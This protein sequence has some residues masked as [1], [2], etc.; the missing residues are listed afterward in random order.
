[1]YRRPP[2]STRTDTLFPY[3]TLFRSLDIGSHALAVTRT[4]RAAAATR[5][6]TA[7]RAQI[8]AACP[9]DATTGLAKGADALRAYVAAL[10]KDVATIAAPTD[11]LTALEAAVDD[12]KATQAAAPGRQDESRHAPAAAENTT[13]G[14]A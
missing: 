7:V 1:M 10:D 2:R 5:E 3:P 13:T 4:E 14:H 12:A 9:G 11:N 8:S 6:L